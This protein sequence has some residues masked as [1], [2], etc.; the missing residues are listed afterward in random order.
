VRDAPVRMVKYRHA[1]RRMRWEFVKRE[2]RLV[3][4]GN[5]RPSVLD[6]YCHNRG[7]AVRL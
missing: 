4:M 7:I 3:R 5:G 2:H 6:K 1:A